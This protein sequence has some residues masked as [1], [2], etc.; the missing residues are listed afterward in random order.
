MHSTDSRYITYAFDCVTN[1]NLR[2]E[3]S[4]VLLSRGLGSHGP[5]ECGMG[6]ILSTVGLWS[7][8]CVP[9]L[10]RRL[11]NTFILIR[12]INVN[13]SVW[14]NL[15]NGWTVMKLSINSVQQARQQERHGMIF[16][17]RF[18]PAPLCLCFVNGWKS[19]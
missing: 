11:R 18:Y 17:N 2:G 16:D 15:S 4:R 6:R 9:P 5:T 3:D 10:Q 12:L 7:I 13:T 19:R 1:L 8:D 14:Q